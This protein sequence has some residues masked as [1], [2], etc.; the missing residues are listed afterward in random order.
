MLDFNQ[1]R[2]GGM[3]MIFAHHSFDYMLDSFEKI[4]IKQ[5]EIWAPCEH[6]DLRMPALSDVKSLRRKIEGRGFKV[7]CITPEQC[8]YP[9]NIASKDTD[10]RKYAVEHF[11]KYITATAE[12]GVERMLCGA[13]WG[14][15]DEDP[16]EA[17]KRSI[18]SLD[19][20][21]RHA[22]KEDVD[23]AFEILNHY[24]TNLV[25]SL[26][27]M[28]RVAR[29]IVSPRFK[30]CVD[31]VPVE[32]DGKK[33]S[34]FFD[35][36]GKQ[37]CHIHMTD[38]DPLGHVPPG[39]GKYNMEEYFRTLQKYDYE[40]NVTIEICDNTWSNNPARATEIGYSYLKKA[41]ELSK[42]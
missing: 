27:T 9:Y 33:L 1:E 11:K 8:Y 20:M 18:E 40:G 31:T 22:E 21:V 17:W 16:E 38:G 41:L 24:E 10:V 5:F 13:G 29:E 37:I 14:N 36:F 6:L 35:A 39:L 2:I 32:L 19:E 26:D 15:V 12:L 4:G 3:N 30:L 42:L 25:Y 23:L 34:D 28:K 7:V